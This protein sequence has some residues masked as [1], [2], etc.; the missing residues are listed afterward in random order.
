[1][2]F[3]DA[4]RSRLSLAVFALGLAL[5]LIG[6]PGDASGA[7]GADQSTASGKIP[8]PKP[9]SHRG[10]WLEF[11]GTSADVTVNE[12]G[13]HGRACYA[14]HERN[15]CFECHNT[16]KPRDHNHTWRTLSHGFMAAGNRER[17]LTCHRQDYCVRC[18]N[19]TAPRTHRGN[20]SDRHCNWCH[21]GF[22]IT[23][24]DNCVVCHKRAPHLSVPPLHPPIGAQ[25]DCT[26]SGCH[27]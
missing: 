1:M 8:F 16:V 26:Q 15:D 12:S 21:F 2:I 11:H 7:Q 4:T 24:E 13:Q 17:C 9:N 20:W 25:T 27:Q 10:N 6:S 23:P 3:E 22:G 18:H 5:A 14:C 19:E